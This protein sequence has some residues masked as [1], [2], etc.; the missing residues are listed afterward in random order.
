MPLS[1]IRNNIIKMNTDA[2]VN[3]TNTNLETSGGVCGAIFNAAGITKLKKACDKLAPIN[4][5]S[6]VITKGYAL[7][8]KYIIHTAGP[9]YINGN[10]YERNLLGSCYTNSLNLAKS[11]NCESISFPLI[12]SGRLNYPKEDALDIAIASIKEWLL[13]NEMDVYIVVYDKKSFVIS[14]NLLGDV[15]TFINEHYIDE[16]KTN[17]W[18]GIGSDAT[19]LI[20]AEHRDD[21][22]QGS[23]TADDGSSMADD[24]NGMADDG[25]YSKNMELPSSVDEDGKTFPRQAISTSF[26]MQEK[27]RKSYNQRQKSRGTSVSEILHGM[28][29]PFSMVLLKLIDYKG[30]TDVD[31]YKRANID[32]RLFSKIRIGNGYIPSKKTVIALAIALELT[33]PEVHKL[34]EHAGYALSPSVP[35][36]VIIEYFI[37]GKKY[38]I[39]EINNVLFEYDM[40]LLGGLS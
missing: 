33:L 25:S 38:D 34:L 32:R 18:K 29:E 27:S 30:K 11:Y 4:I 40:P 17:V 24:G 19:V 21:M 37:I 31:V 22:P 3:S 39:F 5:G 36:D 7:R 35:F 28:D 12:S 6:A 15:R 9:V 23:G 26:D 16:Y 2:I 13:L 1:I 14:K 10:N 8:S 20:N